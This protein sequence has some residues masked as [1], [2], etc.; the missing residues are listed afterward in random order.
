M[1]NK[2][3][4]NIFMVIA[5]S[6]ELLTLPV[7]SSAKEAIQQWE[8][9]NPEGVIKIEPMKVHPHPST[10]E[11]K[12]VVLRANGKHN[13]D[14][15]LARVAELLEKEV[16]DVKI[17]KAWEVAPDTNTISQNPDVSKQF[18]E[19]VASFKPDLVIGSQCD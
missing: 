6:F 11:G 9:I 8:L 1:K 3:F 10:L 19:K 7:A 4:L 13:A 17:V 18:A 14:N 2:R 12:T 5:I 15:F 16:K